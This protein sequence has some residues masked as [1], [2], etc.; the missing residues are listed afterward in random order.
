MPCPVAIFPQVPVLLLLPL[1]P[2]LLLLRVPLMML[3]PKGS[4]I[5]AILYLP[6]PADARPQLR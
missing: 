5:G 2:L 6:K 1:L 4:P 3:P